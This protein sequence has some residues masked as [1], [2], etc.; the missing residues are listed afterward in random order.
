MSQNIRHNGIIE[1]IEGDSVFVR[2]VQQSACSGCHAKSMC[3]AAES[4]VKVIEITDYSGKYQVNEDVTICGQSSLG[5]QAVLLAFVLP[6]VIVIGMIAIGHSIG[7]EDGTNALV[8]LLTL[9]PYYSILYLKRDKLK[10]KF[11]FT[12][13]KANI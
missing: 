9:L 8:G 12:L 13:Q 2:I 10:K 3:S 4:K 6:L 1:R 5:L 11:V 7:W